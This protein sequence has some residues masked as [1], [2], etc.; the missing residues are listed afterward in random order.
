MELL[1]IYDDK[2]HS[3]AVCHIVFSPVNSLTF[4][5]SSYDK[6]TYIWD[7]SPGDRSVKLRHSLSGHTWTVEALTWSMNG[8]YLFSGSWD[9]T[10]R[11]WDPWSGEC[12]LV[13]KTSY[14]VACMACSPD[15]VHIA[16]NGK[17]GTVHIWDTSS[18]DEFMRLA[19]QSSNVVSLVYS[20]DGRR[21]ITGTELGQITIWETSTG[22]SIHG[23]MEP[24]SFPI[25]GLSFQPSG[26]VFQFS[27]LS[28]YVAVYDANTFE[29]IYAHRRRMG[30][31][32][33]SE[34]NPRDGKFV[35]RLFNRTDVSIWDA[36]TCDMMF[37]STAIHG[38]DIWF[39]SFSPC[40]RWFACG[41]VYGHLRIW[42]IHE[43]EVFRP[44]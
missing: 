14:I 20:P 8:Q 21:I 36:R 17:H 32:V 6:L 4:A 26:N 44:M 30:D 1:S 9:T 5:T 2:P 31:S 15:D 13:M 19:R 38:W 22:A 39:M 43:S 33:P 18:G 16:S 37:E 28:I 25:R 40:G 24:T 35:A 12:K 3:D 29:P 34:K 7:L 41:S 27:S 10:V 11:K 42:E 23:P